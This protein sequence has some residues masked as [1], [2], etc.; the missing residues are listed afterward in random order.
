MDPKKT[1]INCESYFYFWRRRDCTA[2]AE[3]AIVFSLSSLCSVAPAATADGGGGGGG[4][5]RGGGLAS[6]ETSKSEEEGGEGAT[7]K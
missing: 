4:G 7:T 2:N 1:S 5:G 6:K 3:T